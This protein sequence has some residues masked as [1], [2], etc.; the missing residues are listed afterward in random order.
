M[1]EL[2]A[3]RREIAGKPFVLFDPLGQLALEGESLLVGL[4]EIR[5]MLRESP[6]R[7]F[8]IGILLLEQDDGSG[9][10]SFEVL[11]GLSSLRDLRVTSRK[12]LG[13][14]FGVGGTDIYRGELPLQRLP[15]GGCFRFGGGQIG[16]LLHKVLSR[17]GGPRRATLFRPVEGLH[18]LIQLNG[19]GMVRADHLTETALEVGGL[20][21]GRIAGR[22]YW[23]TE[24]F[25]RL[26]NDV[27]IRQRGAEHF[28]AGALIGDGG[29]LASM[30]I[31]REPQSSHPIKLPHA[32]SPAR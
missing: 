2:L 9:K 18:R 27:G 11:V 10:S 25:C 19:E 16:L 1:R 12:P 4:R 32:G 22:V 15:K 30:F 24:F 8:T 26:R 14:R 23:R 6:G 21:S 13:G 28:V 20:L 17:S 5:F 31:R 7:R 29:N 3:S